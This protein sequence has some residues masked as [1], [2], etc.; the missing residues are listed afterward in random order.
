V[1]PVFKGTL[2][3]ALALC[4]ALPAGASAKASPARVKLV[5]CDISETPAQSLGAFEGRMRALPGTARMSMRFTLLER[6]GTP[7]FEPVR[8][9]ELATW[10]HSRPGVEVFSYTQRLRALERGGEYRMRVDFR[11]QDARGRTLEST[12]RRSGVCGRSGPLP[13]LLIAAV[14][15]RPGAAA[16]TAEYMVDVSNLGDLD[17]AKVPVL[18]VVDGA[19][20]DIQE[21][22][23]LEPGET[24]TVRFSGPPC[25]HRVRA[26]VDPD[27][28]IH[29]SNETDNRRV[30][31]CSEL[32]PEGLLG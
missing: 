17:A 14:R 16:G 12:R 8:V 32:T 4:L 31:R 28:Q 1:I 20:L 23:S 19:A 21:I 6:F 9:P 15:T 29:E 18:L 10:R 24:A 2:V 13:Q 25:A 3:C 5:G 30:V 7:G 22:Q 27:G 26:E 11:W